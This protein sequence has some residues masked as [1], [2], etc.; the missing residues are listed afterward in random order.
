MTTNVTR[1]CFTTQHQTCK[2]K[3]KTHFWSETGLVLR[4]TVSDHITARYTHTHANRR[5]Q[6]HLAQSDKQWCSSTQ[7]RRVSRSHWSNAIT[8]QSYGDARTHDARPPRQSHM[9]SRIFN[10]NAVPNLNI[11]LW[12]TRILASL[13]PISCSMYFQ[14]RRQGVDWVDMS[15]PLFPEGVPEIDADPMSFFSGGQSGLKFDSASRP[16]LEARTVVH[17]TF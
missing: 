7:P 14:G 6:L 3:T 2:T 10:D 17:R 15:T 13:L 5:H 1:P 12:Q 9:K 4:S 8:E 16:P 11:D